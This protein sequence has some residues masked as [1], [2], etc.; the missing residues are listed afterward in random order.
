MKN[1]KV[2]DSLRFGNHTKSC[3]EISLGF[4]EVKTKHPSGKIKI[5]DGFTFNNNLYTIE[6]HNK[7]IKHDSNIL[8]TAEILKDTG[9][10]IKHTLIN[11]THI[12]N[13]KFTILYMLTNVPGETENKSVKIHYLIC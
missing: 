7:N 10:N 4:S 12:I 6:V 1:L 2:S 8:L 3:K 9:N 13:G 5:P 11:H